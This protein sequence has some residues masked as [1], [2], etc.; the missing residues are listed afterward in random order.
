MDLDQYMMMCRMKL[1]QELLML[2]L[3][4]LLETKGLSKKGKNSI[5]QTVCE[6]LKYEDCKT[7]MITQI[8]KI[9]KE[10]SFGGD[11]DA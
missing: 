5:V 2:K 9:F 7:P 8:L 10:K 4:A 1:G 3:V 11:D 6:D